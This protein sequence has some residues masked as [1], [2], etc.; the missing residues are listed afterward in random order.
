MG[1]K[2]IYCPSHRQY[3]ASCAGLSTLRSSWLGASVNNRLS[4]FA[5][6][7]VWRCTGSLVSSGHCGGV[8]WV[9]ALLWSR[10]R[11]VKQLCNPLDADQGAPHSNQ[12]PEDWLG[13]GTRDRH[14][15]VLAQPAGVSLET[16]WRCCRARKW[17]RCWAVMTRIATGERGEVVFPWTA[18]NRWPFLGTGSAATCQA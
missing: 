14:V 11:S 2:Y 9:S 16:E 4:G 3:P 17:G 13:V 8:G 7:G 18:L 15:A 12:E 6:V 1:M 5:E 10:V